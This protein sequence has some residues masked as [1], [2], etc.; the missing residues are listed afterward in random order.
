MWARLPKSDRIHAVVYTPGTFEDFDASVTVRFIEAHR[1]Y[2]SAGLEV[3]SSE[4]G[5]YVIRVS[6]QGTY[7]IGWHDKGEWGG[8][9][10]NWAA[11]PALRDE[12]GKPNRLRVLLRGDQIR[13]YL[14]GVLAT[15]LRDGRFSAGKVRLVL[16][17]GEKSPIVAAFSDLQLRE[18]KSE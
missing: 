3:R 9:L 17:P 7:Q 15:S 8:T 12:M 6:A 2:A 5:D 16:T 4:A 18:A 10:L 11:H 13:V 1:E 14:N